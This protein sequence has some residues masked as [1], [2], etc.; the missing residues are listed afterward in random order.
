VR[1]CGFSF[2][3]N[4]LANDYPVVE[5]VRSVL[6][7]C[8]E[9]QLVVARS[10]DGT[11]EFLRAELDDPRVVISEA[12][13]D[14]SLRTG[15]RILARLTDVALER[16]TGDWG[17]YVQADEAMHERY[18]PAVRACME[19]HLD[20]REVQ[21]L[22]FRFRHF[23]G[24]YGTIHTGRQWY[25]REVRVI[26]LGIAARRR[27]KSWGDAMGFRFPDGKKPRVVW[28]ADAEVFHYGWARPEE[29]FR[30]KQR[31]FARLYVPD[32]A[33][34]EGRLTRPDEPIYKNSRYIVPFSGT[35][36]APMNARVSAARAPL[37]SGPYT[38]TPGR[39]ALEW[40]EHRLGVRFGEPRNFRLLAGKPGPA[41]FPAKP[42]PFDTPPTV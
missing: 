24:G 26:R 15:G 7:L 3:R 16:C 31:S 30:A 35:H 17:L 2:V 32:D 4:A 36:P 29:S 14:E 20:R 13:W 37:L 40:I 1:V 10:T 41:G 38:D 28:A 33:E 39:R 42:L 23:Y 21:G 19:Y 18:H 22:L 9:F 27:L 5:A 34:L 6:P 11:L 12:P 25:R 8:D